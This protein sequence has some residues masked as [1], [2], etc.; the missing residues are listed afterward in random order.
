MSQTDFV[1]VGRSDND[2]SHFKGFQSGSNVITT[3]TPYQIKRYKALQCEQLHKY[4]AN[5]AY[6]PTHQQ[7]M[8]Q[9]IHEKQLH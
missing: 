1:V 5:N 2:C 7:D 4:Q 6:L 9:F 3:Y 8:I